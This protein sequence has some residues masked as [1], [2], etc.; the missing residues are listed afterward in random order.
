VAFVNG[1][2]LTSSADRGR[3]GNHEHPR[4]PVLATVTSTRSKVETE[5]FSR[6]LLDLTA[7]GLR[8]HCSDP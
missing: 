7:R 1:A 4:H 6:K 8:T 3:P 2:G 5:R